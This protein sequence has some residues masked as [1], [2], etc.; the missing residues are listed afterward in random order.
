MSGDRD[1]S[2]SDFAMLVTIG[3]AASI[4]GL[5]WLWGGVA[6]ALFGDGW[7]AIGAGQLWGV[8]T[9]LPSHLDG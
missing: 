6:G 2:I 8:L 3:S 7:P 1:G 4:A 5:L 9:A